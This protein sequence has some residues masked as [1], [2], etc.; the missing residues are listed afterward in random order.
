ME[1]RATTQT[2]HYPRTE[3]T[4]RTKSQLVEHLS[5]MEPISLQLASNIKHQEKQVQDNG[6]CKIFKRRYLGRID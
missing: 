2:N 1:H 5:G 6:A 4:F 3:P